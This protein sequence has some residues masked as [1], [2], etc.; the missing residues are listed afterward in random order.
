MQLGYNHALRSID[1]KGTIGSHVRNRSQENIL[2]H[3]LK[4]F[5]IRIRAI[6]FQLSLQ[7]YAISKTTL[8]TFIY[9]I[10]GRIDIVI[11]ELKNEIVSRVG[12]REVLCEHL[13]Q[14]VI[15]AFLRRSIQLQEVLERL[16]L[17]IEEIRKWHRIL[18]A[19]KVY[20]IVNDFR[21]H[22]NNDCYLRRG[23][24]N[25]VYLAFIWQFILHI[26]TPVDE[27][28]VGIGRI[29]EIWPYMTQKVKNL[30]LRDS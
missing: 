20:S 14:T 24:D 23:T 3:R 6:Q 28:C 25:P 29:K 26:K 12:D 27:C 1:N 21:S 5:M 4:I 17:H 19:A 13:I 11:Q 7:R 9:G 10:A 18:N 30:L 22:K 15:L 16:Q 8:K 2:Y